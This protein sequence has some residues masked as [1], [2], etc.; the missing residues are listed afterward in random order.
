MVQE[1]STLG[2]GRSHASCVWG[3]GSPRQGHQGAWRMS[4]AA[5][6][7]AQMATSSTSGKTY[8]REEAEYLEKQPLKEPQN[9]RTVWVGKDL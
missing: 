7:V 3:S 1:L 5:P 4:G 6:P 2:G 8:G 9:H